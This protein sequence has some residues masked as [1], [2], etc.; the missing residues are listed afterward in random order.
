MLWQDCAPNDL[1]A[2][3]PETTMDR[4]TTR[5]QTWWI[6]EQSAVEGAIRI[7]SAGA[8]M[9]WIPS[10]NEFTFDDY[11]RFVADDVSRWLPTTLT[12]E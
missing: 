1:T 5:R 2:V 10:V 12:R 4:P 9:S 8:I 6:R 7:R 3:L 11:L